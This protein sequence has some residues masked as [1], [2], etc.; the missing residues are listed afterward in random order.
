MLSQTPNQI[1]IDRANTSYDAWEA[2]T[3]PYEEALQIMEEV[4]RESRSHDMN[5]ALLAGLNNKVILLRDAGMIEL[6]LTTNQEMAKLA[7]GL[8]HY[9]Y[10]SYAEY[11]RGDIYRRQGRNELAR[12]S[13]REAYQ[14]AN[15]ANDHLAAAYALH[16]EGRIVL[17]L[18]QSSLAWI[19]G[20]KG[21]TSIEQYRLGTTEAD[22][23]YVSLQSSLYQLLALAEAQQEHWGKAWEF[24]GHALERAGRR[25]S[26]LEMGNTYCV[27]AELADRSVSA[28]EGMS[29]DI[30]QYFSM[31]QGYHEQAH[32][33]V[34][35]A[36]TH[37]LYGKHLHKVGRHAD[38]VDH[39]EAACGLFKKL[40]H[41]ADF[42]RASKL[43]ITCRQQL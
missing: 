8:K 39:L 5:D 7:E 2:G 9:R 30:D 3:I 28:P 4:I 21:L 6:A 23:I 35:L 33:E 25:N 41:G 43:L 37:Y 22:L 19:L 15:L 29:L 14:F 32:A 17:A 18:G 40:Q 36:E 12:K 24:A 10:L 16:A 13:F 26:L 34:E 20:E 38:A 42:L 31:A 1:L 27:F 11:T